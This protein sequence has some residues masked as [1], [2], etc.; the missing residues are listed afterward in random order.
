[1]W[2]KLRIGS[3]LFGLFLLLFLASVV[4]AQTETPQPRPTPTN[5]ARTIG[6]QG[7]EDF[8]AG[9]IRGSVYRDV[10]GDGQCVDTG[11][12]GEDPVEGIPV[13]FVS[14]DK[15]TVITLKSGSNG[16]YGLAAA[17]YSYWS[18]TAKPG[19]EWTVTSEKTRSVPIFA[20]SLVATGVDFCI[21]KGAAAVV[22]VVILPA[23]GAPATGSLGL[24]ALFGLGLV[25]VVVGLA[26][27]WR[28]RLSR[29]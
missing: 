8:Q 19:A 10:N 17:G 28:S 23:S 1:M 3:L 2:Q 9:T 29:W 12:A 6:A 5:E 27:H 24:L 13:E 11:V 7:D 16:T 22:D 14:S 26:W 4:Q 15:E 21:Q 20:D 18:V 25:M